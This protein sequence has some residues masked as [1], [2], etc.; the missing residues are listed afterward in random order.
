MAPRDSERYFKA[1]QRD[2]KQMEKK[3][4]GKILLCVAFFH[5]SFLIS[6]KI[7]ISPAMNEGMQIITGLPYI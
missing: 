5:P 3:H 4:A 2:I 1:K 7:R 6:A